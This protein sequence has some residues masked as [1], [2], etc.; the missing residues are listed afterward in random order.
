MFG[1]GWS[2][3]WSRRLL[4]G[5]PNSRFGLTLRKYAFSLLRLF[6]ILYFLVPTKDLGFCGSC[7]PLALPLGKL[8]GSSLPSSWEAAGKLPL[9]WEAAG[10]LP[11]L[12]LGSYWEAGKLLP[13]LQKAARKLPPLLLG[14]CRFVPTE[15]AIA[16]L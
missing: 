9:S 8:L 7:Q 4:V 14:S 16:R 1:P 11:P 2:R 10:K 12:L 5:S 15:E 3:A 6:K 13:V